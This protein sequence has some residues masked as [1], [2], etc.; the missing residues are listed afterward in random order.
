MQLYAYYMILLAIPI[1]IPEVARVVQDLLPLVDLVLEAVLPLLE[2]EVVVVLLLAVVAVEA[3]MGVELEVF[4][5]VTD[6]G[7]VRSKAK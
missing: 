1:A 4:S 5:W 6:L 2:V 3:D 7:I